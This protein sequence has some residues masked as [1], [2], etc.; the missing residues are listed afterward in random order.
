[1]NPVNKSVII[2]PKRETTNTFSPE[3]WNNVV[4]IIT[5]VISRVPKPANVIGI[6][7][8]ALATGNNSRK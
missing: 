1:M 8:A 7:P 5:A 3:T 4:N 6:N 2:N